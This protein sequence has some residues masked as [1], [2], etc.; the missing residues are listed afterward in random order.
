[1][2]LT[3]FSSDSSSTRAPASEGERDVVIVGTG[4]FALENARHALESDARSVTVLARHEQLVLSR[5]VGYVIDRAHSCA[6]PQ[7]E[8]LQALAAM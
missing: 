3:S 8:V 7:S 4:S 1:M 5:A 6:I 2:A